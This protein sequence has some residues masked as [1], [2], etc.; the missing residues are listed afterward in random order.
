MLCAKVPSR[1]VV[2]NDYSTAAETAPRT[3]TL[4]V[5]SKSARDGE[6]LKYHLC[7]PKRG[8]KSPPAVMYPRDKK[9]VDDHQQVEKEIKYVHV[10]G[11][12]EEEEHLRERFLGSLALQ[13][14]REGPRSAP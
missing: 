12:S 9:F 11:V 8:P 3:G 14:S 4:R 1:M 6:V 13:T 2:T 10:H 7:G 5:W